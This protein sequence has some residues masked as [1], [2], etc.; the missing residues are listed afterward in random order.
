MRAD[1]ENWGR[2]RG[3]FHSKERLIRTNR[4]VAVHRAL[5]IVTGKPSLANA[6]AVQSPVMPAPTTT[7][8]GF[9]LFIYLTASKNFENAA[10]SQ[11]PVSSC[12]VQ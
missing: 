2:T 9:V 3:G 6:S 7:T 11:P 8:F 5:K 1:D 10:V 12:C 4:L